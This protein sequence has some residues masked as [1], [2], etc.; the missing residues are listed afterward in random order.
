MKL[1]SLISLVM[2]LVPAAAD[3]CDTASTCTYAGES[4]THKWFLSR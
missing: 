3:S 1:P 2:V 4:R